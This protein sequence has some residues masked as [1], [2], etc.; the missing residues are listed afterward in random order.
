MSD[1]GNPILDL[2]N[3]PEDLRKLELSRLP[4]LAQELRRFIINSVYQTGGHL[5]AGLGVVELTIALHYVFN[6]PDDR[7]I[8]DVG[9]QCY[10]HKILTGRKEQMATLRHTGGLCGF[11]SREE[12]VYDAF[13]TG[14]S[15]TSISA[16]L[17]MAIA[18]KAKGE[19]RQAIAVIGD[20]AMTAGQAFEAL[21]HAACVQANLLVILNDNDMS[22]SP[23]VGMLAKY[24][25]GL[26]SDVDGTKS[27]AIVHLEDHGMSLTGPV[28]GHHLPTLVKTLQ[29]L[30]EKSG[31]KL[32]H[33]VTRKGK[34]LPEAEADPV[35]YHA[36]AKITA[37][38]DKPRQPT[39]AN[40]FGEWICD[41]AR[42][43]QRLFAITP[44]MRE[45]SDLVRFSQQF[46][47]RYSDVA[48]AEQHAVTLAGGLACEGMKPVLAIYST[49][50]QRGYDQLIHDVALQNLDVLFALDRAGLVG[51]DGPTHHGLYDI[52]ALRAIPNMVVMA[53]SDE[54]E[55][56]QMLDF[57]Y[58][59]VGPAAVR[60]PR[61]AAAQPAVSGLDF[62]VE[63][64]KG[65]YLRQGKN[66]A[67]LGF[68]PLVAEALKVAEKINATVVDMRFIKPLDKELVLQLAQSHSCLVTLEEGAAKGGI[69]EEVAC[70]VQSNRAVA[71]HAEVVVMGI[72][73]RFIPH[74]SRSDQMIQCGLTADGILELITSRLK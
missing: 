61:G 67:I 13:G 53:P 49:F 6:T 71:N 25:R 9:H 43:D 62:S 44:A 35:R 47:E 28:P 4:L 16:A 42:G 5:G 65:R 50:L 36:V 29:T 52:A 18:A 73:D 22:I 20:G 8:W 39:W 1:T 59:H 70:L 34:G 55:L 45:G 26:Q 19:D 24:L 48:I 40:R 54:Q 30:R 60:Y 23:S 15:S 72:P 37:E 21:N 69:G 17:G 46:P 33:V 32:L 41:K 7:L 12:S 14:H 64:G 74:G 3:G 38:E 58:E 2:L 31:P 10:P 57:G 11:P 68:G 51:D 66:I 56:R 27:D 63:L